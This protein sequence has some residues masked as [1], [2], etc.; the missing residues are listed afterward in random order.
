MHIYVDMYIHS[1]RVIAIDIHKTTRIHSQK[2]MHIDIEIYVYIYIC[3]D[4]HIYSKRIIAID[5]QKNC[6]HAFSK[7]CAYR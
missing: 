4:I 7:E 3:I 6:T 2:N 5:I 1:K